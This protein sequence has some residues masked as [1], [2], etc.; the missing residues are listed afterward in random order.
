MPGPQPKHPIELNEE[1]VEKLT[2]LILSYTQ[3]FCQ[4]QRAKILLLAQDH[5]QWNNQQIGQ[6]VG[7]DRQTV[8]GWRRQWCQEGNLEDS[9]RPGTPRHFSPL[10]RAQIV[11]LACTNPAEHGKV[12]KRWSG[13]KL[14]QV[15]L[16]KEMVE[17][18]SPS[19]IRRWLRQDKIKP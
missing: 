4:V 3:P 14:T 18:I 19:T 1:Q 10:L 12:W 11:A 9:P 16:E 17:S 6:A 8:R 15:A 5:P 13:E 7:C 2:H